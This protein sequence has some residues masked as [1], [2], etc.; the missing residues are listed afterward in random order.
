MK[1]SEN[2]GG[3]IVEKY[4]M[5]ETEAKIRLSEKEFN[6]L[7]E[8]LGSPDFILQKNWGYF[9]DENMLRIREEDEKRYVTL[10][11]KSLEKKANGYNS[12]EEIEFG[13]SDIEAAKKVFEIF[14]LPAEC[15]Y[16][17]KR[18]TV[19]KKDCVICF[20]KINENQYFIEVEGEEKDIE[21]ILKEFNLES[22]PIETRNYF[23]IIKGGYQE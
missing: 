3:L 20:D 15:Y 17:K 6:D 16:E 9:F 7:Y 10:K 2:M 8:K 23:Q 12:R 11:R 1:T 14:G 19:N 21:R 22:K 13:I 5:I 4:N 18:A